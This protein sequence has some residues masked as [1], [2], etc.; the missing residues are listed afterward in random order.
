LLKKLHILYPKG[1][2]VFTPYLYHL[3]TK[4]G[5]PFQNNLRSNGLT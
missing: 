5:G 1:R 3:M 4:K 2:S